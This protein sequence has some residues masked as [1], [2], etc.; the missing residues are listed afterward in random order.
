M[1][2]YFL[3]KLIDHAER[4]NRRESLIKVLYVMKN[5]A[6]Y[7]IKNIMALS[8]SKT[9]KI[10][11]IIGNNANGNMNTVA[12]GF[13]IFRRFRPKKTISIPRITSW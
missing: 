13:A 11:N 12:I 10:P 7:K 1:L 3:N 6:L 9:S 2:T 8:E 4:R 5:A